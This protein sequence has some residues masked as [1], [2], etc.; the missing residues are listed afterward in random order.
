MPHALR[1]LA[2][3]PGFTAVA[4]LILALG[5]GFSTSSFSVANFL[6]LR[7]LPY[8]EPDRLVRIFATASNTQNGGHAPGNA[9]DL[10]DTATS[11]T[12][13]AFYNPDRLTLAH[14]DGPAEQVFVTIV[15]TNFFDVIGSR[16]L[17]GRGFA[18]D[19]DQ[20]GKANVTVL[21][22]ATWARR[23]GSDPAILGRTVRFDTR[24][25]IV[26]GVL[27]P[28]FD[29][30]FVWGGAVEFFCPRFTYPGMRTQRDGARMM[31]AF[32]R[33]K[34]GV[35]VSAAQTELDT[36]ARQLAL[37]YPKDNAGRGLRLTSLHDSN[38]NG[39]TRTVVWLGTGLSVAMM[40]I[41]CANLASLQMARALG[42][43]RDFAVRA[44]LGGNRWQLMT[45]LLAEGL[46]IALMGGAAGL[47]VAAWSNDIVGRYLD[48]GSGPIL[49]LP[50]DARV[51]GFA[52]LSALL[53]GLAF[54][55]LPA[56]LSA[57]ASAADALKENARGSTAGRNQHRWKGL[58]IVGQLAIAFALVGI[59]ASFG[60]GFKTFYQRDLGWQINGLFSG[61][62][63]LSPTHYSTLPEQNAF[64]TT[65]LE[66]LNALPGVES[67]ALCG[68]LPMFSSGNAQ[69]IAVEGRPADQPGREPIAFNNSVS[70]GYFATTKI[71]LK[72]G[73][74]FA[75][76]LKASDPAV[77]IVNESFARQFWPGANPIGRRIRI[78]S[79]DTWH[80]IVGV[81]GDVQVAAQTTPPA[82]RLQ[83]Y[84]PQVQTGNRYLGLVLRSS[85]APDALLKTLRTTVASLDGNL[86]VSGAGT[87]TSQLERAFA[88]NDLIIVNFSISAGMGL[89]IA[90]IGL[91]GVISQLAQQ[92]RRDIGIR[93][94]LGATAAHILQ[95][96]L[97]EGL[98]LLVVGLLC[99]VAVYYGLNRVLTSAMPEVNFP[100]LW[101]LGLNLTVLSV[102]M[103]VA[104]YLPARR[105]TKVDPMTALRAE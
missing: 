62:I 40:L 51:L 89:L 28:T 8:P 20:D 14:T 73:T 87:V 67:S 17:L 64:T 34:P 44:A 37:A 11:Y 25:F 39:F 82:S 99:G 24:T 72:Q 43:H 48:L 38:M 68:D 45:P 41:A 15:S 49:N 31:Q 66:R 18:A 32:G 7:N 6:L 79:A 55:L 92:R 60:L 101:L 75:P 81:V 33:L 105:A 27:P 12:G 86:A 76:G 21:P 63:V 94:A 85:V 58:L 104:C 70:S 57:R 77:V 22:Y 84:R 65:L 74:D 83:V 46:L 56:W 30:P 50:L 80:E 16:F 69:T 96:M 3:S 95:L 91:S 23:F 97:G 1:Q 9:F 102:V 52:L 98:K 88:S 36:I 26:I 5:I 54:S 59:A 71:P 19:E 90:A 13:V 53:S 78:G 10:R 42:R 100:G 29:A 4:V 93:L 47:L 35:S 103:L 2:K 61:R